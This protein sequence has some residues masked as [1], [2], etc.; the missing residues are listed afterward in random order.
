MISFLGKDV[1]GK[2]DFQKQKKAQNYIIAKNI[3][4][5]W[6]ELEFYD[7][8]FS[9]SVYKYQRYCGNRLYHHFIHRKLKKNKT[10]STLRV[11]TD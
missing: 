1:L 6:K 8:F 2:I 3:L 10:R 9:R 11:V 4:L 7:Y 5:R